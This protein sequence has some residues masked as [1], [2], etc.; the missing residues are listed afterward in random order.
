MKLE[1]AALWENP[2]TRYP[3]LIYFTCKVGLQIWE[4]WAQS[5]SQQIRATLEIIEGVAVTYGL[6]AAGAGNATLTQTGE[7]LKVRK[8]Q[9]EFDDAQV[10]KL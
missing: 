3:C 4:V 2:H 7:D 6:A 10:P 8:A 5:Y 1:L 9:K